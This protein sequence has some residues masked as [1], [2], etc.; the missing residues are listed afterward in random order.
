MENFL[1]QMKNCLDDF[2]TY[3]TSVLGQQLDNLMNTKSVIYDIESF[4][5]KSLIKFLQTLWKLVVLKLL[6]FEYNFISFLEFFGMK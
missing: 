5:Q 1:H 6:F 2:K 4:D 3:L